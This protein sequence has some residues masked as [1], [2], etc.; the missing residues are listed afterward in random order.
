MFLISEDSRL[1]SCSLTL[2]KD[3]QNHFLNSQFSVDIFKKLRN[4]NGFTITD[5]SGYSF[6]FCIN[7]DGA[8]FNKSKKQ[9]ALALKVE[10]RQYLEKV[11]QFISD[12]IQS[13]NPNQ[14]S[15]C[16]FDEFERIVIRNGFLVANVCL[17]CRIM[18][19]IQSP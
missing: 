9:E 11:S 17:K 6:Y 2:T 10:V 7:V 16:G 3:E 13:N 12:N 15:G 4:M 5:E 14:C 19:F 18:Y 8:I 1:G